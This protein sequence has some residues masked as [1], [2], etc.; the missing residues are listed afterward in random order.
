MTG[1]ILTVEHFIAEQEREYPQA[2]GALTDILLQISLAA[3]VIS[4]AVNRAGLIDILGVIG[5][6]N[7]H[8]EEVQKLDDYANDVLLNLL[9]RCG[10]LSGMVSEEEEGFVHVPET[11]DPGPYII[12]FDPLDGSSNIDVNISV[13]TIFSVYRKR[14]EGRKVRKR[15]LLQPGSE[16]VAAGYVLYGSSTMLVFTTGAGVH[17]FTLGPGNR[18]VPALVPEPAHSPRPARTSTAS[19]RPTSTSGRRASSGSWSDSGGLPPTRRRLSSALRRVHGRGLPPHA[20]A[21]GDLHVPGDRRERRRGSSRLLY[22]V[23]PMAMICEQ[24]GGRATDGRRR[25]LDIEP[26]GLHHRVPTFLGTPELVETAGRYL[27]DD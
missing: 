19:T 15:D 6:T 7:V 17:G 23:A 3:K 27:A 1:S 4:A 26:E 16:Q 24:A 9:R 18:R 20:P 2:T 12:A 14:S 8:G 13:G 5:S 21:R 25:I 10:S 22:E 11:R